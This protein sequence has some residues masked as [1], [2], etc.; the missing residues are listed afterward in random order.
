MDLH[1]TSMD[2]RHDGRVSEGCLKHVDESR[3]GPP[4]TWVEDDQHQYE[5]AQTEKTGPNVPP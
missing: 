2:D 5:D 4:N 3:P 1:Y